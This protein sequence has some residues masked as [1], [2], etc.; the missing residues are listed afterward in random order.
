LN[1]IRRE[2]ISKN[3]QIKIDT[4][5]EIADGLI[6]LF[7][8]TQFDYNLLVIDL[9]FTNDKY[10]ALTSLIFENA[11]KKGVP[12][13]IFSGY[14]GDSS[15]VLN[16]YSGSPKFL[17]AFVKENRNELIESILRFAEFRS[18]NIV[19]ISDFHYDSALT[20]DQRV[21]QEARFKTMVEKLRE[22]HLSKKIDLIIFSGDFAYKNPKEDLDECYQIIQD[23]ITN[24]IKD[25]SKLLIIPGNHD[26]IWDDF[27][28]GKISEKPAYEF[29]L[30]LKKIYS[31]DYEILSS[32]IGYNKNTEEFE[33]HFE[34]D[35]FCWA[36]SILDLNLEIIGI[37]T[38]TIDPAFKGLG[39][40]SQ[41]TLKY[42][43]KIWL[44]KAA[45]NVV[46]IAILHHNI[47]PPFSINTL[48]ESSNILN[49]GQV[50]KTLAECGCNIILSGHCHD[51]YLYNFS[52]SVLNHNGFNDMGHITYL[53]TGTTGGYVGPLDRAR[54][55]NFINLIPSKI[56]SSKNIVVTPVIYDSNQRKWIE[57]GE[58]KC[59]ILK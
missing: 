49:A 31:N 11:Q 30:F 21:E 59:Q 35:S 58:T 24:T 23:V 2:I 46:R 29:Y 56:D 33:S 47:L 39:K 37:N 6:S 41:N 10:K 54:S 15:Q 36:K 53:S 26:V 43:N 1:A 17:G 38:V 50:V 32:L 51:S 48:S 45:E 34:P 40:V 8:T 27:G 3:P 22:Y 14:I 7:Q 52:F 55:L 18:L 42:I 44:L 12:F 5:Y 16:N 57:Q 4:Q 25:F 19:H 20:G 9:E 28:N 13:V